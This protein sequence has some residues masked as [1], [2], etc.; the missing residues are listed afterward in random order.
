MFT[1]LYIREL[2]NYLYSLRFQVSF[3]IV[4]LVFALGSVSFV[5]SFK[6]M[7]DNYAKYSASQQEEL[8][9]LSKNVSSVATQMRNFVI[10]P[11]EN[12]VIA[13]CKEAYLPNRI[14]YNA[15]NVFNYSV[16][17]DSN[18]PLLV[19][20]ESLSWS[21]IV[22][23]FLSFIT[24]LFAF[25]AI[26]GEKEDRTL[27]LV[28]SN[29]VPR[30]TFLCS[31]LV[32]IITVVG[33]MEM[34]GILISLII[35]AFSGQ[36]QLNGVF[37]MET[38]GFVMISLLLITTFAVFGLLSSV[39]THHSN[40]SLLISLCFWL[41]A[42]VV[43]PN[44]SIFWAKTLFDIP[45]ADEVARSRREA[46]D[47]INRNAPEGSWASNGVD[48]FLPN[49]K[50][51]AQNITNLMNSNKKYNDAYYLQQFH[52]FHQTRNL[53]LLS[54]IAQFDYMNEAFLGGGY[55][56]FQKNW[57]DLHAF[58]EQFLRWFKN[59]DEKNSG[60][61]HWYNPCV[62]YSTRKKPVAIDQI[63]QYR[64]QIASFGQ[65]IGYIIGYMIAMVNT[66]AGLFVACFYFFERYDVR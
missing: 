15:Y 47:D 7:Q 13:D 59:I 34:V 12:S 33:V 66:I 31:K 37:L 61:P 3:V 52:Q 45:T 46:Y 39:V 36:V 8:T 14:T 18:N 53:T 1:T 57:N 60:S 11:R 20:T 6:D 32:S 64:E 35:L 30:R 49:H 58:Q 27:A 41:F 2:Q 9:K 21:F 50:L 25:D 26:S 38:A 24:L 42:A 48:A 28:F 22:S 56:R 65:R 29:A 40:I 43:I 54:P 10:S 63:P 23:M 19:R 16:R 17:H 55:M 62:V 5:S 44:T 51:R 4:V